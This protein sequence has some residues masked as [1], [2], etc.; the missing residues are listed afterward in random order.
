MWEAPPYLVWRRSQYW[1]LMSW[2]LS[3][4]FPWLSPYSPRLAIRTRELGI[5]GRHALRSPADGLACHVYVCVDGCL[6]LANHLAVRD[7]LRGDPE[8]RAEY[9]N[10]KLA[11]GDRELEDIK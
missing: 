5:P 1:T 7:V 3:K 11:L 8:L 6:A 10:A 4:L 9:G 2:S